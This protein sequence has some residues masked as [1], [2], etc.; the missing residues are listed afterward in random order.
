MALGVM[1][2]VRSRIVLGFMD[3]DI[4]GAWST[5]VQ[6]ALVGPAVARLGERRAMIT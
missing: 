4:V 2:P 6:G 1:I 5:I 3:S